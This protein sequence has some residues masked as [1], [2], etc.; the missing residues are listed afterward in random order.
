MSKRRNQPL[1]PENLP[2]LPIPAPGTKVEAGIVIHLATPIAMII[3]KDG[4]HYF[5]I[6]RK[7]GDMEL[8]ELTPFINDA[9]TKR[10]ASIA[11]ENMK[12]SQNEHSN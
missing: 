3:V 5:P 10:A 2:S 9:V 7:N 8:K 12:K 6:I 1:A 11:V 4:K